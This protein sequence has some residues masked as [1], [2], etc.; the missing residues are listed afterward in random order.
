MSAVRGKSG[1]GCDCGFLDDSSQPGWC[2]HVCHVMSRNVKGY[3]IVCIIFAIIL[4]S[5]SFLGEL[6][7]I[8]NL[9]RRV[10]NKVNAPLELTSGVIGRFKSTV[11]TVNFSLKRISEHN[12]LVIFLL[13]GDPMIDPYPIFL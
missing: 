4:I 12:L 3:D 5:V 11:L 9:R 1:C 6:Q 2:L 13:Q 10:V 8:E 7:F